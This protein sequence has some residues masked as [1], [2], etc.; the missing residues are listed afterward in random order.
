MNLK[1]KA[2]TVL[3]VPYS[4]PEKEAEKVSEVGVPRKGNQKRLAYE[5]KRY[6]E[7]SYPEKEAEEVAEVGAADARVW[8]KPSNM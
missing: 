4:H 8:K 2:V 7:H 5:K 6:P 1:A 3:C